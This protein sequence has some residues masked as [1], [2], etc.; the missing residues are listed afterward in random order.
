MPMDWY[1]APRKGAPEGTVRF[2]FR[3]RLDAERFEEFLGRICH[4]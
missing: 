2:A 4:P 3:W 1:W